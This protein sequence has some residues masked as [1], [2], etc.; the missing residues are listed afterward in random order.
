M[1]TELMP[2]DAFWHWSN[3]KRLGKESSHNY[4]QCEQGSSKFFRP[5]IEL[6]WLPTTRPQ[7]FKRRIIYPLDTA[8]GFPNTYPLDNDLS[9]G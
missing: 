4:E 2:D 8:I 3:S 9:G 5:F 7:L 6:R 1:F